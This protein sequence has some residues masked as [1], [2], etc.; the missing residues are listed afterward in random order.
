M[1]LHSTEALMAG[2]LKS[3]DLGPHA[4]SYGAPHPHHSAHA[5]GPLPPG[6]PMTSLPFGLPH[7]LDT[8]IGFPQGVNTRKQRRERTTFTRGQLDVL[9]DLFGKTRYPDIFMRE[10]VACK[11]KLPE[12]RVQ[13]WFKNRRAKVR[14]QQTHQQSSNANNSKTSSRSTCSS[15]SLSSSR[16]TGSS[17]GNAITNNNSKSNSMTT[18]A[19]SKN[20]TASS[21][22]KQ[23][24]GSNNTSSNNNQLSHQNSNTNNN[25]TASNA[26]N[27]LASIGHN[28][29]PI[30]PMTP[31]SSVSPPVNVICKKELNYGIHNG[32]PGLSDVMKSTVIQDSIKEEMAGMIA[33][34]PLAY[35]NINARLGHGGNSTPLGSNSSIITTPSPPMTPSQNALSYV[36]NH[37]SYFWHS[38]YNQYPN[39]YNT[40]ASYYSQVDYQ[41]QSNYS[42]GH[43]GYSTSNMG[44]TASNTFNGSMT[45][46][47]FASNGLDYM[48]PAPEK[49]GINMV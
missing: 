33:S 16:G 6:M 4:H 14:Q 23:A 8:S 21:A 43:S 28:S 48:S 41:G 49:Y 35:T 5:H 31:T 34:N 27:G 13:V 10:E 2:Y 46:Q 30:L 15:S 18:G 20:T 26:N 40:P 45:S 29:S 24:Q 12:S 1:A 22:L 42:M 9:E 37:E 11:I 25:S 44:L 36:P 38:Q 19:S 39:S 3:S 7:G 17:S 32:V 47:P